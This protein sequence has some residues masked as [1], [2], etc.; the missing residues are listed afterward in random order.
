MGNIYVVDTANSRIVRI[1]NAGLVSAFSISGLT[2][3]S[4]LG[5][6]LFGVTVDSFGNLYISDWTNNRLVLVNVSG[7]ALK[8]ASTNT[9]STSS[10]SP[11]TATVTNLGNQALAFSTNPT[12]TADFTNT[13]AD[14]N[15]CTS[16]TS[17]LAGAACDVAV[18]FTPQSAGTLSAGIT[19]TDNTL[20]VAGSTQ[21]VSV[22]GTA[23]SA[24][25]T[26]STTVAINPTSLTNGQAAAITATVAD[27]TTGH[28]ST[29]PTGSVTFTDTVGST[30]TSLNGGSAV[31]LSAGVAALTGVRLSGIGAHTIS[32]NYGG[33][34]NTF[35]TSSSTAVATLGKASVTISGPATQPGFSIGQAGSVTITV[36]G[37]ATTLAV[38]LGT[39]SYSLLNSSGTSVGSGMPALTAG[40]SSSTASIA[41]PGT[42]AS[43]IYTI[44]LT[45]SGDSNYLATSTA[46]AIQVTIG[47]ATPTIG[48][49]ST[50]NP[51]M[52]T[53][54]VTFTAAVASSAGTPTGTVSFLEG[55]T[56][57]GAVALSGGAAAFTTSSLAAGTHTITAAYAGD[58]N[59]A[60]VT[61]SPVT[62]VIQDFSLSSSGGGSNTPTQTVLPG[63]T[64]SYPLVF[65]PLSGTTFPNAVT[66]SVSGL[67]PG[68]TATITPSILPAGSSLTNVTLTI[69]LPQTTAKLL[70]QPIAFVVWGLLLLPFAG[71][72]RRAGQRMPRALPGLLLAA[73]AL[74]VGAGVSGCGSTGSGFFAHPQQTYSV[75]VTAASGSISHST[76]VTLIVQ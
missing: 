33:V 38:P 57:L 49:T 43:G 71:R 53:T 28:T 47:P 48:L 14:I 17:L 55:T 64:A 59:F 44:S 45:Y 4:T 60:T 67:P 6:L 13:S 72:L 31:S 1:T 20:N 75:V 42:L 15:P 19:V 26:T 52:I 61:S 2:S 40:S 16:S 36:A 11:K 34:S 18:N 27:T 21:Q 70:N 22:S 56:L 25:D 50:P 66:M 69:Q 29:V 76:T 73:A 9:G 3:P 74:V 30:I 32:A 10:D 23:I 58:A 65:G 37:S 54:A 8:F 51:A 7:A 12:Y 41:I 35:N 24:G 46:A 39:L 68:A 62:E 5:S 63:G